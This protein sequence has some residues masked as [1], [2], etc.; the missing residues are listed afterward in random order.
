MTNILTLVFAFLIGAFSLTAC[1]N[2]SPAPGKYERTSTSTDAYGTTRETKAKT[3]VDVDQYGNK[4]ITKETK[5]T[6]DPKG[7]MNKRTS[8][9]KE[10]IEE[11]RE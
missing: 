2:T 5:T 9:S 4:K 11:E 6:T 7:L 1:A 10:V 3:E 8:T